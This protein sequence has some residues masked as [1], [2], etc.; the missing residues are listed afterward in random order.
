VRLHEAD[1]HGRALQLAD[2]LNGERLHGEQ[3]V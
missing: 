1:H 2:L 3:D